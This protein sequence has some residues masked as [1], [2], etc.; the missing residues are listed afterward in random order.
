MY[1]NSLNKKIE[2]KEKKHNLNSPNKISDNSI[3]NEVL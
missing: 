2:K 1:E 3:I